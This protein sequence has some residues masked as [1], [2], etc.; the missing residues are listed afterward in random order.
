MTFRYNGDGGLLAVIASRGSETR[1]YGKAEVEGE[2]GNQHDAFLALKS[3]FGF[4][5][6]SRGDLSLYNRRVPN[7]VWKFAGSFYVELM[8]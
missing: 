1:D 7:D 3:G 2:T 5:L 6:V 4:V 8:D